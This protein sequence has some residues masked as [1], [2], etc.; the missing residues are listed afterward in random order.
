MMEGK[1]QLLSILQV[2]EKLN[3]PKHTL[4]FWEKELNGLLVPMRTNGGQRRY[5]MENLLLL[6]QVK[7]CRDNG[8]GLPEII[9]RIGQSLEGEVSQ[10]SK[11]DLLATRV[12]EAVKTEVYSF[13]KTENHK[14]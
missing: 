2:S 13:F 10:P 4:R 3:V 8:L 11:V 1:D 14:G 7:K 9:Q 12:A 6:G 5:T